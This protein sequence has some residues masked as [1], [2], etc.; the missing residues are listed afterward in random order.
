MKKQKLKKIR[1]VFIFGS[2]ILV[3]FLLVFISLKVRSF[4]L[5]SK[6]FKVKEVKLNLKEE[7]PL[8][9]IGKN[10][11]S[12]DIR[13]I[14]SRLLEIYPQYKNIIVKRIFP[15][16]IFVKFI[17]RKPFFQI[18]L[19]DGF[20]LIDEEL[21]VIFGPGGEAYP[22]LVVVNASLNKNL[23]I[24][25]GKR[26]FFPYAEEVV[27][28]I[29]ELRNNNFFSNFEIPSIFAYTLNDIRFTLAN[30]EIRIGKE[31][32]RERLKLLKELILPRFKG[33]LKDLSYI[34]LRFK[35]PIIGY[36]R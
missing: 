23:D 21:V 22:G 18:K 13:K 7:V 14:S 8:Q 27:S 9:I 17:R 19:K 29:S 25:L 6:L 16:T 15:D 24:Y 10:I 3:I 32:Y 33:E 11:F 26:I 28:L 2:L 4:F 1:L 30:I 36:R 34:D 35:E 5:E 20:W 31:P 12:L